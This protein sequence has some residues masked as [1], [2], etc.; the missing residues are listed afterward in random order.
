MKKTILAFLLFLTLSHWSYAQWKD[1]GNN[2]YINSGFVGIG[3]SSPQSLLDI[4]RVGS[5]NT[6]AILSVQGFENSAA[7]GGYLRLSKSRGITLG[8]QVTTLSGDVM[9]VV[10]Y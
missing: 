8:S 10:D 6:G 7:G 4:Q 9:G 3:T 2:V 1:S 5:V